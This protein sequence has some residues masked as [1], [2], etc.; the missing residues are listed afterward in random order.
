MGQNDHA[1]SACTQR[2]PPQ[3]V[4]QAVEMH[5]PTFQ[6]LP[7]QGVQE[8]SVQAPTGAHRQL[9]V[10][11][12]AGIPL[13]GIRRNTAHVP[14][15]PQLVDTSSGR[16]SQ[17]SQPQASR[18]TTRRRASRRR[19]WRPLQEGDLPNPEL[20]AHWDL[21]RQVQRDVAQLL[22]GPTARPR[23]A[24]AADPPLLR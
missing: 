4:V 21:F 22:G 20:Q 2:L 9:A 17:T 19:E 7:S 13:V 15:V 16:P 8:A 6:V 3:V 11:E 10:E 14:N 5:V 1:P 12:F 23:Q 18:A 24:P